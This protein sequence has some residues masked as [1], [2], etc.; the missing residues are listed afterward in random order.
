MKEQE[1]H[2]ICKEY[3]IKNYKI[4]KD[5]SIDVEGDLYLSNRS[6]TKLKLNFN[7]VS[8]NFYCYN[9]KLTTLVGS[10]KEVGGDF[11]CYSNQLS[12]LEGYNGEYDK[13]YCSNKEKLVRKNKLKILDVL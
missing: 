7:K 9:N 10:P 1:I 2:D 5:G 11:D 12:T 3:D 6:L 13:L 4:N 8:G